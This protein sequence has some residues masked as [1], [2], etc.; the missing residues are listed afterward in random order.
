M[1]LM[2]AG[3][4]IACAGALLGAATLVVDDQ[5]RSAQ[6]VQDGTRLGSIH[7]AMIIF[8]SDSGG[9]LP[10]PG[11]IRRLP[12]SL[13]GDGPPQRVPGRGEED[14]AMNTTAS[15]YSAMIAQNFFNPDL[16]VSPVEPNPNVSVKKDYNYERYHPAAG[17]YWDDSFRADLTDQAHASDAH[18][19]LFGERKR[20]RWRD[21]LSARDAHLSSRGP[22]DG[23][24]NA[25]SL[26]CGPHGSWSGNVVT[27]DNRVLF[28]RTTEPDAIQVEADGA[29]ERDNLFAF[30]TGPEGPD[31]VLT[32]TQSIDADR[33]PT[34]QFD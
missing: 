29:R 33:G 31:L 12:T 26:W 18:L 6:S 1:T 5:Q 4:G 22:K 34:V 13:G 3:M 21:S 16:V 7:K 30:D 17:T 28:I 15:L 10:T 9:R 20:L 23:K 24:P 2:E 27:G 19:V 32:L 8:A 11:L 14:I 25:D